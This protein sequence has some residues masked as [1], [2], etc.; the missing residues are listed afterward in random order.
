MKI[1]FL[2]FDD[3]PNYRESRRLLS[4]VLGSA[5]VCDPV[6]EINAADPALAERLKFA[7]SPTIRINGADIEPGVS[8]PLDHTP[9]CRLYLTTAGL[10]GVP[11][12]RWL[13]EAIKRTNAAS[14]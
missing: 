3:C 2:Y 4:E 11:E 7:G 9:R 5:G 8:D 14:P 12:R 6:D 1:E 13:E 10:R